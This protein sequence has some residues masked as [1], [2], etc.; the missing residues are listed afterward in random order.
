MLFLLLK[1][2]WERGVFMSPLLRMK[3]G[4]MPWSSGGT[5]STFLLEVPLFTSYVKHGTLSTKLTWKNE[6]NKHIVKMRKS[7][8]FNQRDETRTSTHMSLHILLSK[9]SN[10]QMFFGCH[11][12]DWWLVVRRCDVFAK[13]KWWVVKPSFHLPS[14][15][16]RDTVEI[17]FDIWQTTNE[18]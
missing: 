5:W 13:K 14:L 1:K 15:N 16:G 11:V 2:W 12:L 8:Y 9:S 7:Y 10:V 17:S 18:I 3:S 4:L 6:A